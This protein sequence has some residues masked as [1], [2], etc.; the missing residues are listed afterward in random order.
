MKT[1]RTVA[2]VLL[3]CVSLVVSDASDARAQQPIQ[4]VPMTP[5]GGGQDSVLMSELAY[6]IGDTNH[7]IIVPAGFVTDFAS[8]PR[9]IWSVLPP[10]GRYQMAAI[11]HDFL[12]WEQQCTREQADSL[13]RVAMAESLVGPFKR[14]IIWRAVRDF[15]DGAWKANARAKAD[16]Q[17]RIIPPSALPIPVLVTWPEYRTQLFANGV[18]AEQSTSASPPEY[19]TAAGQVNL[20]VP[21]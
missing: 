14:D 15:G 7:I 16:G 12:Y 21:N 5:F 3:G 2:G 4:P 9:A 18:R 19:C 17:P 20:E 1:L 13:L 6:R 11:V 8:T 10:T